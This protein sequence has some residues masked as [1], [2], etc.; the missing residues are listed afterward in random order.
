MALSIMLGKFLRKFSSV[1]QLVHAVEHVHQR[2]RILSPLMFD[3]PCCMPRSL[4][5]ILQALLQ[6]LITLVSLL[7]FF[8]SSLVHA[9]GEL[10]RHALHE[11]AHLLVVGFHLLGE[12]AEFFTQRLLLFRGQLERI[13]GIFIEQLAPLLVGLAQEIAHAFD[14]T[15]A[16]FRGKTTAHQIAQ[17]A[18]HAFFFEQMVGEL[19]ENIIGR[20][21]ENLLRAVPIGIAMDSHLHPTIAQFAVLSKPKWRIGAAASASFLRPLELLATSYK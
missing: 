16:V 4:D 8:D 14:R 12:A 1:Q 2:L 10:A 18:P 5:L 9:V 6:L 17:R 21:K 13:G 19:V 3:L 11:V 15:L 20:R 7:H